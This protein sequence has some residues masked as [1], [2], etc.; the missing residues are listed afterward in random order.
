M[1]ST[2]IV[3]IGMGGFF[4]NFTLQKMNTQSF[5][6]FD[7]SQKNVT[8]YI[9]DSTILN[10]EGLRNLEKNNGLAIAFFENGE[11]LFFTQS[12]PLKQSIAEEALKLNKE[13]QQNASYISQAAEIFTMES[14][15]EE[16]WVAIS[17]IKEDGQDLTV[18]ML[19]NRLEER[20]QENR[21]FFLFLFVLLISFAIL[22]FI[23]YAFIGH[24]IKPIEEN[25]KKQVAFVS[26][27]SHELRSPISVILATVGV[28]KFS[29]EEKKSYFLQKIESECD[30]MTQ[31]MSSLLELAS[32]GNP[33]TSLLKE[34]VQPTEILIETEER[35]RNFA[36]EKGITLI[37]RESTEMLPTIF[38]NRHLILEVLSIYTENAIQYTP[39]NGKIFLST[40]LQGKNVVFSVEDTGFGIPKG[41]EKN[42]FDRFYQGD[43]ARTQK[44]HFG[45]GLSIASEI[46]K[47][48]NGKVFAKNTEEGGAQFSLVLPIKRRK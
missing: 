20:Q 48:H 35:Y 12:N 10:H 26:S 21:V 4:L 14:G 24:S 34:D 1:F 32:L 16:Y 45:L 27:A 30:R 6:D 5:S 44:E 29:P 18:V 13:N 3:L 42:V 40:E 33:K 31:L 41:Q 43:A 11:P 17:T 39:E 9:K 7:N 8:I 19:R 28:L 23:C 38:V 36:S 22:F 15:G 2:G 25:Q 37:V 46:A 47:V